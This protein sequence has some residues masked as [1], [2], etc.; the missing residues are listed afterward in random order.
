[1]LFSFIVCDLSLAGDL[2][3]SCLKQRAR[4]KDSG[5]LL[6]GHDGFLDR[7]DGILFAVFFFYF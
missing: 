6:A 2:F 7:F 3:E 4:I 1:M 5:T